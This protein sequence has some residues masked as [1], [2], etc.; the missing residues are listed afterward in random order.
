MGLTAFNR[1]RREA[2]TA[3]AEPAQPQAQAAK[4]KTKPAPKADA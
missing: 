1:K 2:G 4:P 3:P